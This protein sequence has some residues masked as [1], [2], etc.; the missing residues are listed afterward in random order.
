M[1]AIE[2]GEKCIISKG[3]KAGE[4][5]VV[6]KLLENNFVLVKGEKKERKVS[7]NHLEPVEE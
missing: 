5:V 2:E 4:E 3:R 6:S 1:A 7:I